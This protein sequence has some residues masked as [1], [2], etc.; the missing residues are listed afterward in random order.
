MNSSLQMFGINVVGT[1]FSTTSIAIVVVVLLLLLA[2]VFGAKFLRRRP[3]KLNTV[4]FNQR[5]QEAMAL[6]ANQNT[7]PLAI[8][9][10]DKLL[11][12][13]LRK[14]NYKGKTM[15]ERLVAAQHEIA[16]NDGVWFGHKLR[17]KLVHEDF[18]KLRKK[19]V[20]QAMVGFR[21]ALRDVGALDK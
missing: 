8:I 19:E 17:N 4:Y 2:L 21:N 14:R 3:R 11:D 10:A 20:L 18:T 13:A 15:G 12:E 1:N 5:W 6:C 7:W 9:N 16:E